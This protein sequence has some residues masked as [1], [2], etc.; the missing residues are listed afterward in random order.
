VLA[1]LAERH[2]TSA[3]TIAFAWLLRHPSRPVPVAGSRRID[4]LR[5]AVAALS[6][7]LDAQDWTEV[8]QATA[9]HEVP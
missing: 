6:L 2:G 7:R 9:G 4:A 8:W 3:A 1:R 5:E